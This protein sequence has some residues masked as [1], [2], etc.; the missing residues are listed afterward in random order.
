MAQR[1]IPWLRPPLPFRRNI[2]LIIVLLRRNRH[3]VI[4]LPT[5]SK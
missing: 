4:V 5:Y 2:L 1:G 3:A